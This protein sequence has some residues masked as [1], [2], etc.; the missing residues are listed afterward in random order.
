MDIKHNPKFVPIDDDYEGS[1]GFWRQQA[2]REAVDFVLAASIGE[3]DGRS[4]WFFIRLPS[5]D[6]VLATYPHGDTYSATEAW[7][8]I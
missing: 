6:L 5:G 1:T 2:P 7:R 3:D 8:S 4:E